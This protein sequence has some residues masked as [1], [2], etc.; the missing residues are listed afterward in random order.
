[1][2]FLIFILTV[3]LFATTALAQTTGSLGG[4]VSSADGAIPNAQIVVRDNQTGREFTVQAGGDGSFQV[5]KLEFGTYTVTITAAG[6]KTF[7]ATE[8]KID[9]GVITEWD[10]AETAG[11]EIGAVNNVLIYSINEIQIVSVVY[12][13]IEA[14]RKRISVTIGVDG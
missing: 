13:V 14:R 4:T 12:K 6:F 11:V 5:S 8:L 3:C 9:A 10:D 2:R 1:M 7:S